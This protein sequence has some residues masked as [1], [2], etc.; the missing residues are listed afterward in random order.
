V[1]LCKGKT[2]A[3]TTS[4]S[5]S[6]TTS[7]TTKT[8]AKSSTKETTIIKADS[9]YERTTKTSKKMRN[10]FQT[11]KSLFEEE[12]KKALPS[13]L[14]EVA[15]LDH[16]TNLDIDDIHTASLTGDIVSRYSFNLS[17]LSPNYLFF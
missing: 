7:T 10:R 17:Q 6:T 11:T 8:S 5:T 12:S 16:Q 4:T 1:T 9:I 15:S 3:T 13:K 14:T 2:P